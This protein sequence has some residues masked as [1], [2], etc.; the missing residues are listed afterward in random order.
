[1]NPF[2]SVL[3]IVMSSILWVAEER[4]YFVNAF[5]C[6]IGASGPSQMSCLVLF[7]RAGV[8]SRGTLI[9]FAVGSIS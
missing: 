3:K 4:R 6:C 1:M 8:G 9:L 2:L 7:L 5:F